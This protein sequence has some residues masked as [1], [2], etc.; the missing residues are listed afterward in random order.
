MNKPT[1]KI[2]GSERKKLKKELSKINS[3]LKSFW[4]YHQLDKD[5]S[6]FYGDSTWLMSDESAKNRFEI[7]KIKAK[8]IEE[9]LSILY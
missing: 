4:Y 2:H 5:M 9:E 7:E 6:S 3:F 8:K 1:Y